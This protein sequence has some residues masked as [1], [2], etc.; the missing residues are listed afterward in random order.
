[1][2]LV[3]V[4]ERARIQAGALVSGALVM[5]ILTLTLICRTPITEE[6]YHK[7]VARITRP[8]SKDET[9]VSARLQV[10]S[11]DELAEEQECAGGA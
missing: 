10:L 6:E 4:A 9:S 2:R 3:S 5:H 1:M 7:R 11:M 8:F